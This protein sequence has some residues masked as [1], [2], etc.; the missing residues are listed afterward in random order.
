MIKTVIYRVDASNEMGGIGAYYILEDHHNLALTPEIDD[1]FV[2]MKAGLLWCSFY[3]EKGKRSLFR[4]HLTK[5]RAFDAITK[6]LS[7]SS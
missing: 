7:R 2:V 3:R 6:K 1:S 5:Q 4:L